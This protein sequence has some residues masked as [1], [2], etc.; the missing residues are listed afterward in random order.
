MR[1]VAPHSYF[2]AI[3]S[4]PLIVH[5]TSTGMKDSLINSRE[6]GEFVVNIVSRDLAEKMNLTAA[7]FPPEEDEF[8]WAS[9]ESAPS[10]TVK[11]PRVAATK[12]A[13]ECRVVHI[14]E[15]GNG[16]MVFGQVQMILIDPE[17][18]RDG[19]VDP[20]LLAPI[21]RLGG[22]TYTDAAK[23]LFDLKRPSYE[24]VKDAGGT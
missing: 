23:A 10:I 12:A 18:I 22:S 14:Q 1:N 6:T 8:T 3:S 7:N 24:D 21:G 17:V 2:N 13:F 20:E 15:L 9:L 5:F 4:D 19:R 11:P 16:S